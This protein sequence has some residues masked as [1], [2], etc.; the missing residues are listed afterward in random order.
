MSELNVCL[1]H[2]IDRVRKTYQYITHD[3]RMRRWKNLRSIFTSEN[4][5]WTFDDMAEL[6]SKYGAR[7]TIF[8]LHETIPFNLF[9]PINWK[10]SLGRYS[11]KEQE[12]GKI[13]R[14]FDM[15]GWEI[16]LHGSYRSYRDGS[17]LQMEKK[18]LEEVLGKKVQG[19]RQH[20]LNLNEP[21]TWILQKKAGFSYDASLG[22][23]DGTGYLDQRIGPFVDQ[24]SGMKIIPLT[25]MEACLFM[26][27][28]QDKQ[29]ALKRAL[30]WMDHAQEHAC[31]YTILWHQHMLNEKEFPGYR[32]V[33][34]EILKECKRR[35]ARFWLSRD[36]MPDSKSRA[37]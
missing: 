27:V 9:N 15:G 5:Y 28:G 37:G 32:W 20:Y 30:E 17:L 3:L 11:L 33:Y 12:I 16:G 24:T 35:G 13:I 23:I 26:E 29:K 6:E 8:F 34:E 22:R 31:F 36:V 21:D 18:I 7:S 10:L 14:S 2:D 25:M 19:I 4:P 1:T